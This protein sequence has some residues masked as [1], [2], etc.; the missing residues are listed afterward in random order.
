MEIFTRREGKV[1][2]VSLSGAV[3]GGEA[4]ASLRSTFRGLLD[5]GD[6]LFVFHMTAVPYLDSAG[7]GE[8]V[9]CAK[10]DYERGGAIKIVLA[11]RGPVR[12]IFKV[13]SLDKVF[14]IFEHEAEA[15]ASFEG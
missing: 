4:E 15:V 10:R 12:E 8:L 7:V 2:V 11:P 13:T 9:G 6:R 3:V 1:T 14:E 5:S